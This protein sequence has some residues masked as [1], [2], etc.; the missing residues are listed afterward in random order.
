MLV[1]G[2]SKKWDRWGLAI[3]GRPD[4][5]LSGWAFARRHETIVVEVGVHIALGVT[6]AEVSTLMAMVKT[7]IDPRIVR[8]A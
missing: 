4:A 8:L 3:A 1:V 2:G 7:R 6:C 5:G